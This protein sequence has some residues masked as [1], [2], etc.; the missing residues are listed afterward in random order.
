MKAHMSNN[1]L[2]RVVQPG[3][4]VHPISYP[5]EKLQGREPDHSPPTNTEARKLK[6]SGDV[7]RQRWMEE[8]EE[9]K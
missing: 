7:I 4:G 2:L 9:K 3:S 1:F 8:G 5:K 6:R